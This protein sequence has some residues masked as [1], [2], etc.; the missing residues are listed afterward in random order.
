MDHVEVLKIVTAEIDFRRHGWRAQAAQLHSQP[1]SSLGGMINQSNS[2][3][4]KNTSI[5]DTSSTESRPTT[6]TAL[7]P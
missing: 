5:V 4:E 6:L 7:D 2:P 1:R 3:W